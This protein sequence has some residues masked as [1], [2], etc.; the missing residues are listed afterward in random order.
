MRLLK[1][2]FEALVDE[3]P[4]E[5]A[6]EFLSALETIDASMT[7]GAALRA[8][9]GQVLAITPEALAQIV[10]KAV[11]DAIADYERTRGDLAPRLPASP[12]MLSPWRTKLSQLQD[13]M[14]LDEIEF[15]EASPEP[16][17]RDVPNGLSADMGIDGFGFDDTAA[18][19]PAVS[20]PP[21][22]EPAP[23][24]PVAPLS[25]LTPEEAA[26][27]IFFTFE[28]T[29]PVPPPLPREPRQD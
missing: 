7:T 12:P 16:A 3:D 13:A 4:R 25:C 26:A 15:V 20:A 11:A 19:T 5:E 22:S 24:P 14:G 29:P 8:S 18:V 17:L 23:A 27:T 10:R 28:P 9:P 6:G 1:S 2:K 21:Q